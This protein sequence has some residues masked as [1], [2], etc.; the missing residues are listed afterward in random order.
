MELEMHPHQWERR[1]PDWPAAVVSGLVAGAVMMVLDL[2][3]SAIMSSGDTWRS[4]HLVAAIVL[5]PSALQDSAF[6]IGIVAVALI[7]HYLLGIV[8]ALCLAFI[9]AGFHY[10]SSVSMIESIGIVFGGG[11]Y[12]ISMYGWTNVFPWIAELRGWGSLIG[13][14]VFGMTAAL[15][16]WKLVQRGRV[17]D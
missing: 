5:G 16:Y 4:S 10:E 9:V 17:G 6:S 1:M 8:F 11:V 12:V 2:V 13:H 3:W 7:T 14:M 15:T